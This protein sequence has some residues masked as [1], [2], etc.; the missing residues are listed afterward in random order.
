MYQRLIESLA[1]EHLDTMMFLRQGLFLENDKGEITTV[2][3][4]VICRFS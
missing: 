1:F 2:V 3:W 4:M